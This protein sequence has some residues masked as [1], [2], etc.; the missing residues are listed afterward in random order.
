MTLNQTHPLQL[1]AGA[2][3]AFMAVLY[4]DPPQTQYKARQQCTILNG[5]NCRANGSQQ[6]QAPNS[7]KVWAWNLQLSYS[8]INNN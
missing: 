7:G 1:P 5:G 4:R 6:K 8:L 2:F 3:E